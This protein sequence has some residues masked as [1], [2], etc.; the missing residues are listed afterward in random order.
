M[1]ITKFNKRYFEV[2]K[3]SFID[4]FEFVKRLFASFSNDIVTYLDKNLM[5]ICVEDPKVSL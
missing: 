1:K 4:N 5:V 2:D 3:Q